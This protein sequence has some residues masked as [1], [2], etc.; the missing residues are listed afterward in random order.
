[1]KTWNSQIEGFNDNLNARQQIFHS[2]ALL[3]VHLQR[4]LSTILGT[5]RSDYDYEYEYEYDFWAREAWV[6]A[7]VD[8]VAAVVSSQ[9]KYFSNFCEYEVIAFCQSRECLVDK[10]HKM[11]QSRQNIARQVARDISQCIRAFK[12]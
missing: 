8:T 7:V 3:P 12:D 11:P 9:Q 5:F 2:T 1:M 10:Q 6:L 4:A